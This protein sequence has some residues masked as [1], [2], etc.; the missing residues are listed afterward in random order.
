LIRRSQVLEWRHHLLPDA[1]P[2]YS[3]GYAEQV[4]EVLDG[5]A[6]IENLDCLGRGALFK[7]THLH[8]QLDWGKSY[9]DAL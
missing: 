4:R 9:A 8:H 3:I 5:L 6:A 1:Y 7:Y 2:V